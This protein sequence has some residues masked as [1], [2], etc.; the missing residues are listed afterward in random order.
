[1]Q[2]LER[3]AL[4]GAALQRSLLLRAAGS[5]AVSSAANQ[6]HTPQCGCGACGSGSD[7]ACISAAAHAAPAPPSAAAIRPCS[8]AA[9]GSGTALAS[10]QRPPM[11]APG[12]SAAAS[13]QQHRT[14]RFLRDILGSKDAG[15]VEEAPVP[16]TKLLLQVLS[17]MEPPPTFKQLA[18]EARAQHPEAFPS[19]R[20]AGPGPFAWS[21][22]PARVLALTPRPLPNAAGPS[23]R[24]CRTSRPTA[25]C[26]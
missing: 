23:R 4:L 1:M 6:L 18:A 21:P 25:G 26:C 13:L 8:P 2:A 11:A 3:F 7:G 10:A 15:Q 24:R 12:C 9:W 16:A 5:S 19:N 22:W 17:G 14:I 20:Q